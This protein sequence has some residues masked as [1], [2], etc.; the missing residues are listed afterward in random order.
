MAPEVRLSGPD[1]EPLGQPDGRVA[2]LQVR[3][4]SIW[5][6]FLPL[7]SGVPI[8]GLRQFKYAEQKKAAESKVQAKV[9]EIKKSNSGSSTDDGDYNIK[10]RIKRLKTRQVQDNAS[11]RSE[12]TPRTRL[13]L[14]AQLEMNG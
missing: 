13:A 6:K 3:R 9:I 11:F 10:L 8:D 2:C 14:L 4:M 1:N 12:I 5:S 7:S